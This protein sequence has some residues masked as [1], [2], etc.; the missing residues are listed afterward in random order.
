MDNAEHA[1]LK[2]LYY[3]LERESGLGSISKLY[4]AVKE[5]GKYKLTYNQVRD[6]LQG[7]DTY[8]LHKPARKKYPRNR[9]IAVGRDEIHQ[10]DLVDVAS[11]ARYNDGYKYLLTCIDVFSKYAWVRPLKNKTGPVIINAYE[12]ILQ[13]SKRQPLFVHSDRGRIFVNKNFQNFLKKNGIRFYTTN[14]EVKASIVERFNRTLKGRMWKYFTMR[15]T[16]KYI[17]VLQKL[18][19]GYNQSYHCSIRI[20][21]ADV[22]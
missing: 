4:R 9:V 20:K 12:D 3:D 21:P 14:S 6:F 18:V 5:D 17:A 7:E 13:S 16:L 10:L 2:S 1:Y 22:D 11:L 8:T 19:K 15:S